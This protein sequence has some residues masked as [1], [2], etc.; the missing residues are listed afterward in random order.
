MSLE[1]GKFCEICDED[2]LGHSEC[3]NLDCDECGC[4]VECNHKCYTT[5]RGQRFVR[6]TEA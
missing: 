6:E 5:K 4:L 1:N 3:D 2:E